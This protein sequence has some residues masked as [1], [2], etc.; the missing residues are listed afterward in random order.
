VCKRERER[1][2]EGGREREREREGERGRER[3]KMMM[4][5]AQAHLLSITSV[6][7]SASAAAA[8]FSAADGGG[9]TTSR[10]RRRVSAAETKSARF[11]RLRRKR[12]RPRNDAKGSVHQSSRLEH[13][14]LHESA[15]ETTRKEELRRR[16]RC[17]DSV[18]NARNAR[19]GT[20]VEADG[21]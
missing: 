14:S 11:P 18:H 16:G 6:A 20:S 19:N 12:S 17:Y 15:R 8:G 5:K 2:W 21:G 7:A 4:M 1:E 13:I 3:E 10:E 9:G